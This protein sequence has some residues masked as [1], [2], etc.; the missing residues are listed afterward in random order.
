[1]IL[2]RLSANDDIQ[3]SIEQMTNL[4]SMPFAM[5]TI[6]R[7]KLLWQQHRPESNEL[8]IY[9]TCSSSSFFSTTAVRH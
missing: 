6:R 1:M 8:A 4:I 2:L 7:A 5:V 3:K 9:I